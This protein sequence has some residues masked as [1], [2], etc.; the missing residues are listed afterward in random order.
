MGC[1]QGQNIDKA[2]QKSGPTKR[3]MK[4][5]TGAQ[6]D[7]VPQVRNHQRGKGKGAGKMRD[8]VEIR[9]DTSKP[10]KKKRIVD[11][12]N[13]DDDEDEDRNRPLKAPV[14][15]KGSHHTKLRL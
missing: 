1:Q 11:N 15:A 9:G 10:K 4:R 7:R 2:N 5:L 13:D 12:D 14:M 8:A 3:G 6:A